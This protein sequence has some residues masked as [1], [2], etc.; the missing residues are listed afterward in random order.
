MQISAGSKKLK[1]DPKNFNGLDNVSRIRESGFF[2]Y[3]YGTSN[4]FTE[5]QNHLIAAK[6]KGFKGA[7]I[8]AYLT[9]EKIFIEEA[10]K[11]QI[12]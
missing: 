12:K 6:E 10:L 5:I 4:S 11:T 3:R 2:K 9:G 1:L 7:Y 8:V